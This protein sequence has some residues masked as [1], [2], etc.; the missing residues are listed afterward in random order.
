MEVLWGQA[1]STV[2]GSGAFALCSWCPA[3][4][5]FTGP[6]LFCLAV[7]PVPKKLARSVVPLAY[8]DDIYLVSDNVERL[9][10]AVLT[11]ND[12]LVKLNLSANFNKCGTTRQ[13]PGLEEEIAV[14][15]E[16]KVLGVPLSVSADRDPLIRRQGTS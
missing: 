9:N 16:L 8:M 4:R 14:D 3:A 12:D 2:E 10:K 15:K 7:H 6:F 5:R 1:A 13:V 11:L